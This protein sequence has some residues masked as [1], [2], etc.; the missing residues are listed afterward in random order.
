MND[1]VAHRGPDA[2]GYYLNPE[3]TIGLGHRRLSIIDTSEANNQ[4]FFGH[5]KNHCLVFNGEIYNYAELRHQLT[6]PHHTSGDTEVLINGLVE[7]GL[8]F[9]GGC[10]G[11]FAF[12]WADINERSIVLVRDRVGVKPL[13]VATWPNV[14]AFASEL[15]PIEA[16]AKHQGLNL[17]LNQR[18]VSSL[19]NLGFVP[20]P[21]SMYHEV[22]KQE[23]GTWRHISFDLTQKKV[24]YW[25]L[26][27][28]VEPQKR[29]LSEADAL[30]QLQ[31]LVEDAVA[32]RLVADVP[33][34]C[35]LSGGTDSSL[36]SAVAQKHTDRAMK[37]FTI[38]FDYAEFDESKWAERV[39][40][41]IK[42]DHQT[43]R[44][45][46][47]M[48]YLQ[49]SLDAYDEPLSSASVLPTLMVSTEAQHQVTVA[50]SGDGGDEAF[51]GYGTYRWAQRLNSVAKQAGGYMVSPF[52]KASGHPRFARGANLFTLPRGISVQQHIFSQE[53]S[54][55]HANDLNFM[56]RHYTPPYRLKQE[57]A[58][59]Q[60]SAIE[61]QNIQ[62][63]RYY[64]PDDLLVK[65][66]RASMSVGLEVR[67]PLMDH[68]I[69]QFALNLPVEY[70]MHP[71]KGM[72]YLLKQLLR[73]YLPDE[74]VDRQK[75]GF[76]S[77]LTHWLGG[78]LSNFVEDTLGEERIRAVGLLKHQAV[79]NLRAR[80]ATGKEPW[81]T[82]QMWGLICL[83]KWME[84]R[85]HIWSKP[86]DDRLST[87]ALV[88]SS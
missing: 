26:N 13:F 85:P 27:E 39:A 42:S 49:P 75:W 25:K 38:A 59:R 8:D 51:L 44:E 4:P 22:E 76:P 35:F 14:V 88:A 31:E 66:D 55:F 54:M 58:S 78:A 62:D 30:N 71:S 24:A 10:I 83:Q 17:S 9:L 53:Q 69:V 68:R 47:G 43:N 56:L 74:L 3:G 40:A 11:M 12:A 32:K 67:V 70:R 18:A 81:T 65:V 87:Q 77:P 80:F 36:V 60:L 52:L 61:R 41:H 57:P 16:F 15:G 2:E 82:Y 20:G 64:M 5:D 7:R 63:Y 86:A 28:Q 72:K 34:G 21:L 84:A 48:S 6:S 23:P 46:E 50:L 45:A 33:L 37:T 1:C 73:R 19:L 79:A 29:P